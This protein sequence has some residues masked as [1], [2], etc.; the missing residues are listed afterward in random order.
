MEYLGFMSFDPVT[1]AGT[2]LNTLILFYMYKRFLF[3]KVNA[4][5]DARNSEVSKTYEEA[6]SALENAKKMEKDYEEKLLA[7]KEESAEIVRKATNKAQG[8]YDEI[9]SEANEDSRRIIEKANSDMELEKK[10]AVNQIKDEISDIAVSIA[11]RVVSKEIDA[12]LHERL[13]DDFIRE[14]GDAS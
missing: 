1:I 2:L 4:L 13:I 9:L 10:R 5:L 7:A 12:S 3:D 11:E 8:R 14:I 6:D